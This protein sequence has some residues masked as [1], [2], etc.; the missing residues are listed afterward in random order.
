MA[1]VR[2]SQK[3]FVEHHLLHWSFLGTTRDDARKVWE[4]L[5]LTVEPDDIRK[6]CGGPNG[7]TIEMKLWIVT[8]ISYV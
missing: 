5:M 4:G 7:D 2:I 8:T 1:W 3:A 6:R